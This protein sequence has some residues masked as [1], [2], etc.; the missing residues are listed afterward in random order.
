MQA[1][2]TLENPDKYMYLLLEMRVCLL[3]PSLRV[4][5]RVGTSWSLRGKL[6]EEY[7]VQVK[8]QT[9]EPAFLDQTC[10]ILG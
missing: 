7:C 4:G 6:E 9:M 8:P 3:N 10:I 2:F 1:L 5:L